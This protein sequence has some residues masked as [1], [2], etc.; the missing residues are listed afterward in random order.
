MGYRFAR[1]AFLTTVA[2]AAATALAGCYL[3]IGFDSDPRSTPLEITQPPQSRTVSAGQTASFVVGVTGGG[4]LTFQWQR[5]GLAIAGARGSAYTTP[6]TTLADD[7]ALFT[8]RVCDD[9]V[10]LTSSPALLSVM[11]TP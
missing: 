2:P 3:S 10:C 1:I 5:N 4:R 8:V 6:P 11:R 9:L 7:G